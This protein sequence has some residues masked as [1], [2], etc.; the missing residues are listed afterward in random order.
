MSETL[1]LGELF[2]PKS[3]LAISEHV[4]PHWS[5]VG[6]IVFITFRCAD[7]IPK[8]VLG[9]WE[10]E[11]QDWLARHDCAPNEHWSKVLPTLDQSLQQKFRK[12]FIRCREEFLDS[13]QGQCVL[14][15]PEL[16]QIVADTL[17]HFDGERYRMG[18]FI[19][20]PNHVHLLASFATQDSL[21]KQCDSWLHFSARQINLALGRKGKF[22]QQEPFDHLVRNPAQYEYLR[23]YIRQNG[24][25]A[26][27]RANEYLYRAFSG[28]A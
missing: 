23:T 16:A 3:D 24:S 27:L 8:E 11:K 22:W 28:T 7:S 21:A 9:R 15:K 25:K 14:R 6:A 5:Q 1:Q 10:R 26:G 12:A 13:C 19:V 18:D 20:M 17:M 2:D 4:R